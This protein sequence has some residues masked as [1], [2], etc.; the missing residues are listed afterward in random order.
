MPHAGKN[1]PACSG[2]RI[3][4]VFRRHMYVAFKQP[5]LTGSALALPTGGWNLDAEFDSRLK[6][7]LTFK[8]WARLA[9]FCE[10]EREPGRAG[11]G[12]RRLRFS[13]RSS[14]G[15]LTNPFRF[16]AE[17]FKNLSRRLHERGRTAQEEHRTG[18]L[19]N[20]LGDKIAM[21][22]AVRPSPFRIGLRQQH[23]ISK[24]LRARLQ[25]VQFLAKH[26]VARGADA[27]EQGRLSVQAKI[28]DG[29]EHPDHRRNAAAGGE[30][31][32]PLVAGIEA[33]LPERSGRLHRHADGCLVVE[34]HRHAAV[35]HSL[36][37]DLDVPRSGRRGADRIA[38][39]LFL[40]IEQ[41]GERQ[42]L[43]G[44][45]VKLAIASNGEAQS[46]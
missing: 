4:T 25:L 27:I 15:F 31:N 8:R 37:R 7:G 22:V 21:N 28:V 24:I 1:K 41:E 46:P 26:D 42:K 23:V 3:Q 18:E 9:G 38:A 34:E 14:E 2:F 45:S 39:R 6:Q 43:A 13:A 5:R 29:A 44:Q 32:D 16:D 17:L 30:Q 33:E 11:G 20:S 35:R 19:R 36:W 10:F 12:N 40:A